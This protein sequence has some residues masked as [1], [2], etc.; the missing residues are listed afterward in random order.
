[1]PVVVWAQGLGKSVQAYA[2]L[3]S[4]T[5]SSFC[6]KQLVESLKLIGR[7]EMLSLTTL[8]AKIKLLR[9]RLSV[10]RYLI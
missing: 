3:D 10:C 2:L 4:G 7:E 6:S 8:E 5:T 1:M 9:Q